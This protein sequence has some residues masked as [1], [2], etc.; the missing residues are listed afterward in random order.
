MALGSI[1]SGLSK[2]FLTL[3][4]RMCKAP[5]S[6]VAIVVNS[7]ITATEP[8]CNYLQQKTSEPMKNSS[9][10]WDKK[11]LRDILM[12]TYMEDKVFMFHLS[13]PEPLAQKILPSFILPNHL[14]EE[15]ELVSLLVPIINTAKEIFM[16]RLLNDNKAM[17]YNK[18]R[19]NRLLDV[20]ARKQNRELTELAE[21]AASLRKVAEAK[22]VTTGFREVSTGKLDRLSRV[23]VPPAEFEQFYSLLDKL[24]LLAI[25]GQPHI[26]K[27]ATA[28][29]LAKKISSDK[30]YLRIIEAIDHESAKSGDLNSI[31]GSIVIFDDLFGEAQYEYIGP[32]LKFIRMLLDQNNYIILTSRE[33]IFDEAKIKTKILDELPQLAPDMLQEGSYR[34]AEL[35]KILMNHI[36][37]AKQSGELSWDTETQIYTNKSYILN[38]LRF[39]HNIEMFVNNCKL[40]I[41]SR[42]DIRAAIEMSKKINELVER[43]IVQGTEEER[44]ILLL[45]ALIREVRLTQLE[46]LLSVIGHKK[47][48]FHLTIKSYRS[49]MIADPEQNMLKYKHPSFRESVMNYFEKNDKSAITLI[50]FRL[51]EAANSLFIS[52]KPLH[53]IIFRI[54]RE[55]DTCT[56][57]QLFKDKDISIDVNTI[58][59]S[60]LLHSDP[61]VAVETF[62]KMDKQYP[63]K[64][65]IRL[66]TRHSMEQALGFIADGL[67]SSRIQYSKRLARLISL[68]LRTSIYK[69]L[70]VYHALDSK[71][72]L[73]LRFKV[74]LLTPICHKL[75]ESAILEIRYLLWNDM[76]ENIRISLYGVL[77]EFQG[78]Y[79]PIVLE[80]MREQLW[81]EKSPAGIKRL[82]RSLSSLNK[83]HCPEEGIQ[84][85]T[86]SFMIEFMRYGFYEI[87]QRCIN[88]GY[89]SNDV[90]KILRDVVKSLHP[91]SIYQGF[92][93]KY[94]DQ[95]W[96][97]RSGLMDT[98]E[99]ELIRAVE[100][101]R[102][103]AQ[104]N[105]NSN[106]EQGF[107]KLCYYLWDTLND[108]NTFESSVLEEI[109]ND[110]D[111][112][113]NYQEPYLKH[114]LYDRMTDYI[115]E[116]SIA[117][118]EPNRLITF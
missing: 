14:L 109:R 65:P 25:V 64:S 101:L 52:L 43:I 110:I 4:K 48:Q 85:T 8:H 66:T 50:T 31:S 91:Q 96:Q 32:N 5:K 15:S 78:V 68:L 69:T 21:I 11:R 16:E 104:E 46:H 34:T 114:D 98:V 3:W 88:M 103:E 7:L 27:S 29:M 90:E 6:T 79:I 28:Y 107:G 72:A 74:S 57:E 97:I 26:G 47:E 61:A 94:Y 86:I 92:F 70:E 41:D 95:A 12:K 81:V 100:K 60:N 117:H 24:H 80:M 93:M 23:F 112:L 19:D 22:P 106:W 54:T 62:L 115:V 111:A 38:E 73:E 39:P 45:C 56:L 13:E 84:P 49:L 9:E 83:K 40:N 35:E 59:F 30:G 67:K 87:L 42:V 2:V 99:G 108:T 75:P 20:L 1:I 17:D 113:L 53:H 58:L 10:F 37:L 76:P 55:M 33:Y 63:L 18:L 105:Q 82:K 36:K 118:N 71:N 77:S 89:N 44:N 116:W 51:L 102:C